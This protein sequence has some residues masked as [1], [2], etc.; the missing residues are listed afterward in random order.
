MIKHCLVVSFA[1]LAKS[2]LANEVRPYELEVL[3]FSRAQPSQ[4]ISESFLG[5]E[6]RAPEHFDFEFALQ[7]GF[8]NLRLL[9]G[10][11]KILKNAALLIETQMG[12]QILFH[13]RWIYPL[14][15]KNTYT[16]WFK[17][18]GEGKPGETLTGYM[19]WSIDRY[20]ELDADLRVTREDQ[21]YDVNGN[22]IPD[23]YVLREFRKLSSQDIHYL[24]HPAF[25]VII[26][27]QMVDQPSPGSLN[28]FAIEGSESEMQ[29]QPQQPQ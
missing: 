28:P 1:L 19:Q 20:I 21:R 6:P 2:L 8:K 13:E 17:I 5:K 16:P 22:M 11:E 26:A 18:V 24:D 10:P 29:S 23:V 25:G 7:T 4:S 14:S 12:G 3:I 15:K 27:S 9:S